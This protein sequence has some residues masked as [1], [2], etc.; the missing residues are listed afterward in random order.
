VNHERHTDGA[1]I[2][3]DCDLTAQAV[4]IGTGAGGAAVARELSEAGLDVVMLE[5]GP[6]LTAS[7]YGKL[8][9]I[10]ATRMLY[11]DQGLTAS[12]GAPPVLM[13]M[14][15]VVGGTTVINL[16]TVLRMHPEHFELWQRAGVTNLKWK[17]LEDAYGRVEELMPVRATAEAGLGPNTRILME[18]LKKQ[19]IDGEVLTRNA[20]ECRGAGRCFLGCPTDAKRAVHLDWVPRALERGA[21]LI[22]RC[23][24]ERVLVERGRAV[25]VE[26]SVLGP[27]ETRRHRVTVKA[28]HVIVAA[29]ALLSPVLLHASGLGTRHA[30]SGRNLGVHPACRAIG[31]Y[32]EPVN[33]HRG[34]PQAYHAPY[35]KPGEMYLET[36]F[37]PPALMAAALPGFGSLHHE[38]MRRYDHLAL[39]GFR[40]IETQRGQVRRSFAG[41]PVIEYG[42]SH[43]DLATVKAG[44]KLCA[45]MLFDTGAKR[46]FVPVH[47]M[48]ALERVDDVTRLDDPK[49]APEDLELSGYHAHGTLRMGSDPRTAVVA[50]DGAYHGVPG[51][52]VADASLFPTS[53]RV[54]PQHTVMALATLVGRAVITASSPPKGG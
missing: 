11:R 5:E 34:V 28:A 12:Q 44:L 29:G 4:V 31:L 2:A 27:H 46:V 49:I 8:G 16:G 54:N 18:G 21:R 45:K 3:A 35:G 38:L 13:P 1:H 19:A 25:G 17:Q 43:Q 7:D 33:G 10:D 20:P 14:G 39:T 6:Y 23:R 52:W 51:L 32:D 41:L 47:G 24:V 40:I 48:E 30:M 37:L 22:S 15:R 9:T 53:S 26:A 36:A 42:L 50:E